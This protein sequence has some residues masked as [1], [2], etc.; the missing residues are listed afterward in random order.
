[1]NASHRL[2]RALIGDIDSEGYA[3]V[4][5]ASKRYPDDGEFQ[6]IIKKYDD[7]RDT[8]LLKARLEKLYESRKLTAGGT[9]LQFRDRR[10]LKSD[11]GGI[12]DY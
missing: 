9:R 7:D 12:E 11:K 5:R 3:A 2:I 6:V 1:M 10:R 8:A 4:E